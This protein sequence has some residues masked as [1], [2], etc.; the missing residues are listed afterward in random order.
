[1]ALQQDLDDPMSTCEKHNKHQKALALNL[2]TTIFC[3][4]AKIRAGKGVARRFLRVRGTSVPLAKTTYAYDKE[5]SD[6]LYGS[7]TRYV[8]DRAFSPCSTA[9]G[10]NS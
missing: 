1:M 5:V 7:G 3:S 10:I 2:D 4:F 8:S 6:R 9:S